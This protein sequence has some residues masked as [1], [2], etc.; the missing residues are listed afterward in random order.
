[1]PDKIDQKS[2]H[3]FVNMTRTN[4]TPETGVETKK[5]ETVDLV[6][7]DFRAV[8]NESQR[9]RTSS[10]RFIETRRGQ[11]IAAVDIQVG[12]SQVRSRYRAK[13]RLAHP[14]RKRLGHFSL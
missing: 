7:M 12:V 5:S 8:E 1:V 9:T 3:R 2:R 11:N 6:E 13:M 10:Q 4:D 14:S